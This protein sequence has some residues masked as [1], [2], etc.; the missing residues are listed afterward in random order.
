MSA[1]GTTN[2]NCRGSAAGRRARKHWLLDTFGDGTYAPCSY[3]RVE[4]DF[5]T[6]TV[7][8]IIPGCDG[9]TYC[10]D[11]IQPACM[12]CNSLEGTALRERRKRERVPA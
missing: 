12:S 9:G 2:T 11:N 7:D 4:L 8:R 5:G 1:R 10:R 3:C 6:I